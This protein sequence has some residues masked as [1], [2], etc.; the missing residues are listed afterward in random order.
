MLLVNNVSM[1]FGSRV[2]FK[3]VNLKLLARMVQEN[4]LF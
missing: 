1:Q 3:D 4:L 2:L